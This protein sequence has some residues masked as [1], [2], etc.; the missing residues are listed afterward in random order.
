MFLGCLLL[1][2]VWSRYDFKTA[3]PKAMIP[4]L[5]PVDFASATPATLEVANV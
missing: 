2:L 5:A 1:L 4:I 3:A